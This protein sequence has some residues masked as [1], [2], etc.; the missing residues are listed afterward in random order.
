MRDSRVGVMG[1]AAVS[2]IFLIKTA[3]LVSINS[4][5]LMTALVIAPAAGRTSIL[6]SMALLPYARDNEGLGTLFYSGATRSAALFSLLIF[7]VMSYLMAP[8]KTMLVVA[9]VILVT[10]CFAF[11]CRRRIGGSTGD[12]LGAVCELTEA[13]VL[14]AFSLTLN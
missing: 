1:A 9:T 8:A 11:L 12:T 5:E 2:A 3:A 7:V 4:N 6:C 14:L 13:A 10:L